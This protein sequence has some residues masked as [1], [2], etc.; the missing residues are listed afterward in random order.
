MISEGNIEDVIISLLKEKGYQYIDKENNEWLE[1]REL[2]EFINHDL[3]LRCLKK[4]NSD[5]ISNKDIFLQAINK[6]TNLDN[7]NLIERN[8]T[9]HKYLISGMTIDSKDCEV[10]P[11]IHFVD[12]KNPE[13]NVFQVCRQV[14][15]KEDRNIRIPDVIIYINGLPLIVMELKSFDPNGQKTNLDYAFR[16]LGQDTNSDGYRFDIPTLFNYNAFLVISDGTTAKIGT[17]TS[18]ITRFNEWK[19]VDGEK[20]YDDKYTR[21][22]NTLIDGLFETHRLLDFIKYNIFFV[23]DENEKRI[24]IMA[25]Y[26]QYF[27]VKKA[28]ESVLKAKK[29]E[30]DGKGGIIWHTQGSGKSFTMLMLAHRLLKEPKLEVPT[31]VVLTDR[32]DLDAQLSKTFSCAKD[33]LGT[34]PKIAKSRKDLVDKLGKLKQ[35]G[36]IFATVGKFDKDDLPKNERSNIFVMTDEAHRGHY[37]IYE[38]A[39]LKRKKEIDQIIA[40]FKYGVEKYIRDALPNAT[41]IGFTGTPISTKDKRTTDIF[42]EIIDI[43][44]MT[45]SVIDRST[46]GITVESRC[47]HASLDKTILKQIDDYYTDLLVTEQADSFSIEKSKSAM[48]KINVILEDDDLIDLFAKDIVSHYRNRKDF[49]NGKA[50]IICQTRTAAKKLY[51]KITE[52][53]APELKEQTVLV[54]TESNKDSEADR[55]LFKN[56]AWRNEVGIEFKKTNSK[57]KI[58]I[59]CDMWLTGFDVPDLDVMYFIKKLKSHNLMQAIARVNRIYSGK[60]NGLIVDY[61]GLKKDLNNALLEY[62]DRDRQNPTL[63]LDSVYQ[64]I[65]KPNLDI[66]NQ[67]L[68]EIDRSG[69]F[70]EDAV[71]KFK[72]V[73]DGAEVV[74]INKS[75]EENFL[76]NVSQKI[77]T[78]YQICSGIV[79]DEERRDILYFLTIR[80]YILKLNSNIS[81]V[82]SS[83]IDEY[84]SK[85]LLEAIKADSVEVLKPTNENKSI[86]ELL[87][88]EKIEELRH[89]NPPSIFVKI[90]KKLFEGA[91]A[92]YRAENFLKSQEFSEKLRTILEKYNDRDSTTDFET[93]LTCLTEFAT[94]ILDDEKEQTNLGISGRERAFYDALIKDKNVKKLIDDATLKLIAIE[95]KKVIEEFADVDWQYKDATKARMRVKIRECLKKYNYPSNYVEVAISDIYDQTAHME[96]HYWNLLPFIGY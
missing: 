82:S 17:L 12:F 81:I 62:T 38:N 46:V 35:G 43:Y 28:F 55:V 68:K 34:E 83:E 70:T 25:Q 90:A 33:Y 39:L 20:G 3:L 26:H 36:I 94:E 23:H 41:F 88:P 64:N 58:A 45:Q 19:S 54:V 96:I 44:D 27:G 95:L 76:N 16:Q 6:I 31:I 30:G 22:I 85:L 8:F 59:V 56:S 65:L 9:F 18:S 61:I 13:N 84:V 10:N 5:K 77:K 7:S 40:E 11:L 49:L 50:M 86:F 78:A 92:K 57:Y 60:E 47:A 42:G 69:F 14:K 89:K 24:K 91:I 48:S 51:L 52:E 72:A 2:N 4:I 15:F 75:T 53:V 79:S 67:Q 21:K 71:K 1:N 32:I 37:G 87:S 74:L 29:P 80:Q 63:V 73:Q 66:L 93:I